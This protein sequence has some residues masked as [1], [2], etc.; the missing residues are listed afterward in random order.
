MKSIAIGLAPSLAFLDTVQAGNDLPE[1]RI[2]N[3]ENQG[4]HFRQATGT[5]TDID[6]SPY[7]GM[8]GHLRYG[9]PPCQVGSAVWS[10]SSNHLLAENTVACSPRLFISSTPHKHGPCV[11]TTRHTL[12]VDV[13]LKAALSRDDPRKLQ[14]PTY[15]QAVVC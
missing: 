8:E 2:V 3:T 4:E 15:D 1:A 14:N 10:A 6:L 13:R 5:Y 11:S 7:G 12:P 9:L